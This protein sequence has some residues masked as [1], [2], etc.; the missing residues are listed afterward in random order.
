MGQ[1][2]GHLC[3]QKDGQEAHEAER[4]AG[5]EQHE[6]DPRRNSP[7]QCRNDDLGYPESRRGEL[8]R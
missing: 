3:R 4:R 6:E 7:V 1:K 5:R 2:T 8:E